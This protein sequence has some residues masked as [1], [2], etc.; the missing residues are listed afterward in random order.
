ML[1]IIGH[2]IGTIL[3]AF[4]RILLWAVVSAAIGAGVV[5]A[6]I[7][8][9]THQLPWPPRDPLT[10]AA[11]IG[12]AA[13]SAYAGGVTALMTEAVRAL[14]D[15]TKIAE[16]EMAAPLEAVARDLRGDQR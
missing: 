4:W 16:H 13:L 7:Y 1:S 12:V 2:L 10:L 8:V 3:R 14:K 15:A 5:L 11:L 6:V 9:N